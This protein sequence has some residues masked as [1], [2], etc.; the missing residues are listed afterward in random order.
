[1]DLV[2]KGRGIKVSNRAREMVQRKLERLERHA[3]GVQRVEMVLIEEPTPRVDGGHRVEGTAI[4]PRGR[5][6]ASAAGRHLEAL[7]E[8]VVHKL[9]RQVRDHRGKRRAKL[10]GGANR[11][12]SAMTES[13]E[14]LPSDAALDDAEPG[15]SHGQEGR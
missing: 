15:V 6:H 13:A 4:A 3:P 1:M 11:V 7:V 14:P 12:K 10:L 8:K 2:V 9:E 5:F